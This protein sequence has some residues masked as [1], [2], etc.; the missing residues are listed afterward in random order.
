[1]FGQ[2]R[3]R[4]MDCGRRGVKVSQS[5]MSTRTPKKQLSRMIGSAAIAT[6]GTGS[7]GHRLDLH[8]VHHSIY[9]LS[10]IL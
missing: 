3:R 10:D 8:G 2:R 9:Q 6:L 1:L 7:S 5:A 4:L